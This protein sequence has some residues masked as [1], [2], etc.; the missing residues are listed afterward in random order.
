MSTNRRFQLNK[1]RYVVDKIDWSN[2]GLAW[3]PEGFS[4]D[5]NSLRMAILRKRIHKLFR[6]LLFP[7]VRMKKGGFYKR[8]IY[9]DAQNALCNVLGAIGEA[10]LGKH[11]SRAPYSPSRVAKVSYQG[12]EVRDITSLGLFVT[13]VERLTRSLYGNFG[14]QLSSSLRLAVIGVLGMAVKD[15]LIDLWQEYDDACVVDGSLRMPGY[16]V[17]NSDHAAEFEASESIRARARAVR[18]N[19]TRFGKYTLQFVKILDLNFNVHY[20]EKKSRAEKHVH[21]KSRS[22]ST[23]EERF[24]EID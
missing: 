19:P 14:K 1:D 22:K 11:D 7:N 10:H 23:D 17:S 12:A 13:D 5:Q 9:N 24:Y 4:E 6:S 15:D 8:E 2:N 3:F 21:M 20:E 18:A 16:S